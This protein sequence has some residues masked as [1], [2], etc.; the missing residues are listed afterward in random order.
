MIGV[1]P[2]LAV[3]HGT[4]CSNFSYIVGY[5]TAKELAEKY[6]IVYWRGVVDKGLDALK[7]IEGV[8]IGI[9]VGAVKTN[10]DLEKLLLLRRKARRLVAYGTCAVYGGLYGLAALHQLNQGSGGSGENKL[11]LLKVIKPVSSVVEVDILVPGCPPSDELVEKMLKALMEGDSSKKLIAGDRSLC[12]VCPRKPGSSDTIEMPG[13]KRL[14]EAIPDEGKC[15]L[16]QGIPCLGPVTAAGCNLE[17]IRK[18]TPCAGCMGPARGVE[19]MGLRYI[20]AIA[21]ILLV[22]KEK[23]LMPPGLSKEMDKLPELTSILYK[24]TLPTSKL[25]KLNLKRRG[26]E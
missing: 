4:S 16:L 2:K 13:L 8:D 12:S 21:S 3:V 20:S 18:N 25:F 22:S 26:I 5:R 9:Y 24:Y 17:C 10:R 11:G 15:F 1:K 19:D 14:H 7:E 23:Q 6:D